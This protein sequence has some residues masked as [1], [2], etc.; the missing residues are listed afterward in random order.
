MKQ[1]GLLSS[2]TFALLLAQGCAQKSETT[3]VKPV[4][5]VNKISYRDVSNYSVNVATTTTIK[6]TVDKIAQQLVNTLKVKNVGS[7]A[8]TSFVDLHQLNKTT[9]FGRVL[10]E[11]LFNELFKR[12]VKVMDFRGQKSLSINAN[13]EFFLSRNVKKLH[14]PIQNKYVLVGTYTK[15]AEGILIN[16]RI[17]D[18]KNGSVIAT[19]RVIFHSND[20]RIFENCKKPKPEPVIPIRT[21]DITTDGCATEKCP[22]V[23]ADNSIT[24]K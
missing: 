2:L 9:H 5:E 10:G 14:S 13:G 21:I 23:C 22:D 17:V 12:G 6:D 11:S 1:L 19:S 3:T 4:K 20:C 16:S 8:I 18:N 24:C 7:V 15:I